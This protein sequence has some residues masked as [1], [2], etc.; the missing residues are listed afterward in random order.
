MAT[1]LDYDLSLLSKEENCILETGLDYD[2]S[3]L[4]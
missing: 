4:P 2:L 1:A 3:L